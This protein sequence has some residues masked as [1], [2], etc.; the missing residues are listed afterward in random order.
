MTV[1]WAWTHDDPAVTAYRYQIDGE[2]PDGWTV[3]G[4]DVT[5]IEIAGLDAEAEH[6]LHLQRSYDGENWSASATSTAK[7]DLSKQ[8]AVRIYRY[9]GYELK[10][11]VGAGETTIEYPAAASKDAR[12]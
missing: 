9:G 1:R 8:P 11:T 7:A 5:S 3:V 12:A 6:T 2:D 4:S 10:A